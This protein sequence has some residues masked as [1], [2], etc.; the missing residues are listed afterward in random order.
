MEEEEDVVE[1]DMGAVADMEGA[2][3]EAMV[4]IYSCHCHAMRPLKEYLMPITTPS[5]DQI[6]VTNHHIRWQP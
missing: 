3:V 5:T 6:S 4:R 2:V 1:E